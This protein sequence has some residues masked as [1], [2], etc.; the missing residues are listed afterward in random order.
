[1]SKVPQS[2]RMLGRGHSTDAC[3]VPNGS[4]PIV[5]E[6]IPGGKYRKVSGVVCVAVT[7]AILVA[8]SDRTTRG[9]SNQHTVANTH[10]DLIAAARARL[11]AESAGRAAGDPT[12]ASSLSAGDAAMADQAEARRI[13]NQIQAGD[14]TDYGFETLNVVAYPLDR[15]NTDFFAIESGRAHSG[16]DV[17]REME[18]YHRDGQ[19]NSWKATERAY[20]N[21]NI[22]LPPLKIDAT[23]T[24]HLLTATESPPDQISDIANRYAS[25]MNDG[26]ASGKLKAGSFA[27]GPATTG[28]VQSATVFLAKASSH[29]FGS[30]HWAP[31]PGGQAVALTN[32]S[33]IFV[34]VQESQDLHQFTVGTATYFYSQDSKRLTYGG[35]LAPGNYSDISQVFT[36]SIAVVVAPPGLDV[37]AYESTLTA[38]TGILTALQ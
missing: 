33:L 13:G 38:T 7:M 3:W 27:P 18:L 30:I 5:V 10:S 34:S 12:L 1:M 37:V 26:A 17:F 31:R 14:A 19:T 21:A 9:S 4:R 36:V 32:G 35:L 16:G 6:Y 23:G 24:A 29:G 25:T 22:D 8:C 15:G 20:I 2:G 28:M 11:S